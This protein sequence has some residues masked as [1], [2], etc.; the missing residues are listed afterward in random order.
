MF[1][2]QLNLTDTSIMF[3]NRYDLIY[4]VVRRVFKVF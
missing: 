4:V 1:D 2:K 3:R